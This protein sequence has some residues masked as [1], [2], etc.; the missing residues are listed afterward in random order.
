MTYP[1]QKNAAR[2]ALNTVSKYDRPKNRRDMNKIE[3]GAFIS[4]FS[5]SVCLQPFIKK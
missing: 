4:D 3:F 1:D 2:K 5:H